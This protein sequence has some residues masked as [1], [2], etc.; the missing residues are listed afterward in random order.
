MENLLD[1][2]AAAKNIRHQ[3]KKVNAIPAVTN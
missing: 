2:N 1:E 3:R